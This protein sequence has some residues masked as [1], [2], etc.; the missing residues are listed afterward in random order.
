MFQCADSSFET[1]LGQYLPLQYGCTETSNLYDFQ[2]DIFKEIQRSAITF[3][4]RKLLE[5]TSGIWKWYIVCTV[6]LNTVS[7]LKNP[8]IRFCVF[9][10]LKQTGSKYCV[11]FIVLTLGTTEKKCCCDNFSLDCI[12]T[13]H[14]KHHAGELLYYQQNTIE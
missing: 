7:S 6:I 3:L 5:S 2:I 10:L 1:W 11:T 4:L 12:L 13:L 14:W 9:F 8:Y